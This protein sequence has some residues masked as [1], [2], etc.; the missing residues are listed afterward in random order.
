[1]IKTS[2]DL[3]QSSSAIFGNLKKCS[4]MF[5][6]VRLAFGTIWEMFGKWSEI[7]GKSSKTSSLGCVYIINRI[8]HVRLWI[9]ILSSRVELDISRVG[10]RYAHSWDIER[11]LVRYRVQHE[12]IKCVSTRGHVT[13]AISFSLKGG[14]HGSAHVCIIYSP[15][16]A[17]CH[18]PSFH[19]LWTNCKQVTYFCMQ[20]AV[21]SST[22]E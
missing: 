22:I 6:S 5:G 4:E 13:S 7:F 15:V 2:S 19:C 3:L 17:F 11:P 1:M 14:F 21:K 12:K 20:I 16:H 9:R 10:A 18:R 8:L